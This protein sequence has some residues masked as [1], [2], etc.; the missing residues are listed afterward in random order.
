LFFYT[1]LVKNNN[2]REKRITESEIKQLCKHIIRRGAGSPGQLQRAG[3]TSR[4]KFPDQ[5]SLILIAYD[6]LSF[7]EPAL[8]LDPLQKFLQLM[9]NIESGKWPSSSEALSG[10]SKLLKR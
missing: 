10:K 2:A 9:E 6:E 1:E 4:E 3:Q 5:I 7:E 8:G